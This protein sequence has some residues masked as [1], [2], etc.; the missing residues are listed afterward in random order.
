MYRLTAVILALHLMLPITVWAQAKPKDPLDYSLRTYGFMLAIAL[1]GGA[2]SWYAKVRAGDLP[3]WSMFHLIGELMTSALAGLMCFWVCEW[4][5]VPP[6]L[7]AAFTGVAGHAGTRAISRFEQ[8]M[9]RRA[10]KA[11]P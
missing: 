1:L 7:T 9:M 6:L 2:V 5:G 10:Q 8:Y 3:G 4:W 11:G